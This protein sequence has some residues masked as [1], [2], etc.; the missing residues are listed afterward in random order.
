M[1]QRDEGWRPDQALKEWLR[2]AVFPCLA[3]QT[4]PL[5]SDNLEA[6]RDC[7]LVV[8]DQA[9]NARASA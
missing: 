4:R 9:H 7:G 8:V 5:T 6:S 3:D 2:R 1:I